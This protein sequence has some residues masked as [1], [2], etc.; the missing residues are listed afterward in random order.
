MGFELIGRK[1]NITYVFCKKT[2]EC[3]GFDNFGKCVA[4]N[5]MFDMRNTVVKEIN[6]FSVIGSGKECEIYVAGK[7]A[8]IDGVTP[9]DVVKKVSEEL[10]RVWGKTFFMRHKNRVTQILI[11]LE[12]DVTTDEIDAILGLVLNWKEVDWQ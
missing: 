7:V 5:V 3:Y 9:F 1:N 6:I 12:E 10:E 2:K 4:R 8:D 11:P